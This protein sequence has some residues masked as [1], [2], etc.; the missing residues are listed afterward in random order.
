M[1]RNTSF[2][3][4]KFPKP[5][6]NKFTKQASLKIAR[7]LRDQQASNQTRLSQNL[8][9]E[10]K[11]CQI[12]S[13]P[14]SETFEK[15]EDFPSKEPVSSSE[16]LRVVMVGKTGCG[17]S[18]TGN[19]ILGR[20]VFSSKVALNS[21]TRSCRKAEGSV[22]GRPIEIVD[23]PGLFDT[24]LSNAEVQKELV[25][26]ISLLAPGPHAFLLVLQIGRFTKEERETVELIKHFFGINSQDFIFIVFTRGDE[27]RNTTIESYLGED[28]YVQT[29]INDCGGRYHVFNNYSENLEQVKEH[30]ITQFRRISWQQRIVK[31]LYIYVHVKSIFCFPMCHMYIIAFPNAF[32][33][34]FCHIF[35]AICLFCCSFVAFLFCVFV[36]HFCHFYVT[37]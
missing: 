25:N 33:S 1:S 30:I 5:P 31:I 15:L 34:H 3:K 13:L 10:T 12:E 29:M 16:P 26:C 24:T 35:I 2:T 9:Y 8:K 18:A 7:R 19:T 27:L 28:S 36:T 17:K 22:G 23:T 20:D 11:K 6:I 37:L 32:S 14:R 4:D 21:V